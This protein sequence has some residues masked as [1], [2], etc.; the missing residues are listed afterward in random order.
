M[1]SIVLSGMA[2]RWTLRWTLR[3]TVSPYPA[4]TQQGGDH[5]T[6]TPKML[7]VAVI[8][9]PL[10]LGLDWRTR[11]SGYGRRLPERLSC[12]READRGSQ[13]S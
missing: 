3:S 11:G 5:R 7:D 10:C 1:I 9:D 8:E 13:D 2:L 4:S 12:E 6:V